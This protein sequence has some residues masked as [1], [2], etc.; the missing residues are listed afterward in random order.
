MVVSCSFQDLLRG[1]PGLV[2]GCSSSLKMRAVW[3]FRVHFTRSEGGGCA[4]C[5]RSTVV[6]SW[7]TW[8]SIGMFVFLENVRFIV[9]QWSFRFFLERAAVLLLKI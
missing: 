6:K 8:L 5:S 9:V 2:L 1:A 7:H 4:V 3:W